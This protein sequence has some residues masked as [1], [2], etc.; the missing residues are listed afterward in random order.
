ML[1]NNKAPRIEI[2]PLPEDIKIQ[3]KDKIAKVHWETLVEEIKVKVDLARY[4]SA[5]KSFKRLPRKHQI[6]A[7]EKWVKQEHRG[8]FEHATGSGKTYTA[9][10]A[11]RKA[12]EEHKSIIVLV[13]ST[14]LLSQ[15]DK[16]IRLALSDVDLRII[17]CGDGH[18]AWDKEGVLEAA[19]QKNDKSNTIVVSTMDTAVMPRFIQ[20]IKQGAHL[21]V[22]AD[23]VHRMGSLN[24]RNFFVIDA[25]CRLGLS[26]TPRRYGDPVGTQAI[27]KYFGKIIEPPYTLKNAID[28][29]VLTP[30]YYRP[31]VVQLSSF[32]QQAWNE[33]T[34]EI[35]IRY[36][37]C[38]H[39]T[40][41]SLSN[42]QYMQSLLL[43]R[44]RIIKKASG[45]V[46]L[47][48]QILEK[49]Y[50]GGQRWI[51]YCEDKDQLHDVLKEISTIPDI[52]AYEYY[53]DMPGDRSA[54]LN[55]FNDCGGVIV[56]IKCLDEGVDIPAATHAIILASSQN[57]RE[58]I[59]R[60]GRILRKYAGK[61]YSWLY[62]AVVVP[63][64]S[65]GDD[66]IRRNSM[67]VIE[68]PRCIQF[69]MWSKD[70]SCIT[71]LRIIA[72]QHNI[73]DT[74]LIDIGYENE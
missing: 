29:Q 45:K 10:C 63:D 13:P 20:R 19:T 62:D 59:Q 72:L 50:S 2:T 58:F 64:F 32:E 68:L 4:W 5:D 51:I 1:W 46:A 69:G 55:Y 73:D 36:A 31:K 66:E 22:V 8:I 52:D 18:N 43:K 7:L 60:R 40:S 25:G 30:Y 53:A 9:I 34:E 41:Y 17:L 49:E 6:D 21:F 57:P 54:T 23:E 11:V 3:F 42:D 61:Y 47:A 28:D 65:D 27:I 74:L 24:R 15:W 14:D 67:V 39:D 71:Q 16:E 37:R 35:G 48:K 70:P 44:C 38:A 56:S 26:A 12:L 33:L